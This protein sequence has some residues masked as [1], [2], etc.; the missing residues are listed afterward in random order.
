M[1]IYN[2]KEETLFL[3]SVA[4]SNKRLLFILN[5]KKNLHF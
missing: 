5:K 1:Y 3:K 2:L 4:N